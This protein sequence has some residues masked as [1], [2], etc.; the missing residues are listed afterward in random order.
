MKTHSNIRVVNYSTIKTERRERENGFF[1]EGSS[2][3]M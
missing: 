3:G 1:M 2:E